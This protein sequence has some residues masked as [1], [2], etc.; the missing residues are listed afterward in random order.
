MFSTSW[1]G[2]TPPC[3]LMY[4]WTPIASQVEAEHF[5]QSQAPKS[6]MMGGQSSPRAPCCFQTTT[7]LYS[8]HLA[9]L[10]S[11]IPYHCSHQNLDDNLEFGKNFSIYFNLSSFFSKCCHLPR[12]YPYGQPISHLM[13]PQI[14]LSPELLV[15]QL[16]HL[17]ETCQSLTSY[18]CLWYLT[19][20][21][22]RSSESLPIVS[23][24]LLFGCLHH[25][26]EL[27]NL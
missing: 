19:L 27:G 5:S 8:C 4:T 6:W 26:H 23:L 2:V 12:W 7:T 11:T 1:F 22:T 24:P 21:T 9:L 20:S 25:C 15:A 16:S 13:V 18:F 10:F 17:M 3:L 14:L